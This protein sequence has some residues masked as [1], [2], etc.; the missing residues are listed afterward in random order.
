MKNEKLLF[1]GLVALN[2][3]DVLITVLVLLAGG[4]EANPLVQMFITQFGYIGITIAKIP[5][6][7]LLGYII[8]YKWN[9][10]RPKFQNIIRWWLVAMNIVFAG[11]ATYSV[12]LLLTL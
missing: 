9:Q 5:P 7:A 10:I 6:L 2:G 3:L 1:W 11:V 4:S 12:V 8:Y